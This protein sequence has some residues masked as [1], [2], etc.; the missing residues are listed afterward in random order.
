LWTWKIVLPS[1]LMPWM[2][3][4]GKFVFCLD[5]HC[6]YFILKL[7]HLFFLT[8]LFL[9]GPR[10]T[11]MSKTTFPPSSSAFE[12]LERWNLRSSR[13]SSL[14]KTT[15][16]ARPK[17]LKLQLGILLPW[18]YSLNSCIRWL[19]LPFILLW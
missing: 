3:S 17:C 12:H 8:Y 11:I 6:L 18:T 16:L 15:R 4:T 10:C 7:F 9:V 19:F 2:T 5:Y 1:S 13:T 14:P